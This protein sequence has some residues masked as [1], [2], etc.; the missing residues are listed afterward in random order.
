M[1]MKIDRLA[2][3]YERKSTRVET[4]VKAVERQV[5]AHAE[6]KALV[7]E[8]KRAAEQTDGRLRSEMIEI[9][10]NLTT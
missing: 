7:E 8:S 1:Q 2:N 5:Q 9:R 3:E 10:T 6:M 4:T